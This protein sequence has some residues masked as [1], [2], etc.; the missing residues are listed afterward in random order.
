MLRLFTK[1]FRA[2]LLASLLVIVSCGGDGRNGSSSA[3]PSGPPDWQYT[4]MGDSLAAGV[5]VTQGYVVRYETALASDTGKSVGITNLGKSGWTSTDLLNAIQNDPN[6]RNSISGAQVVTW[7]IGG[8]DLL[9]AMGLFIQGQC[10]GADNQQ[11]MRDA[12][13]AFGP[14]WDAI[15]QQILTL[16]NKN[17]TIVRTMDIY[18]PFAAQLI[19]SGQFATLEAYLDEV[20]ARIVATS[21]ANGIPVAK[22]HE[23]FNGPNGTDDPKAKGLITIDGVHPS[24]AGHQA[25][26]DALRAT[27]YAPL[28]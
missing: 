8:D 12:V 11:C 20:N 23:A 21:A 2:V 5:L 7:D 9:H 6:F 1:S 10:G 15:T 4:A 26:A 22:V 13:T 3:F 25:I 14:N 17:Q 27:R 18:N 28:Q 24:D 19:A 16:R